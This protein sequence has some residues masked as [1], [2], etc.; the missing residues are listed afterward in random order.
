MKYSQSELSGRLYMA[1]DD[2]RSKPKRGGKGK[3]GG[4]SPEKRAAF[5]QEYKRLAKKYGL[6]VGG[7]AKKKTAKK[8]TSKK[9]S[10]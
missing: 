2:D 5:Q 10:K 9:K 4:L 8:K 3:I 7:A 6:K 1:S